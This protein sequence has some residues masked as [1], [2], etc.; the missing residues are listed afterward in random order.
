MA[1][2]VADGPVAEAG[3][4]P[5]VGGHGA[6]RSTRAAPAAAYSSRSAAPGE[7]DRPA[8]ALRGEDLL[9][10]DVAVAGVPGQLLDQVHEIQRRV[11]GPRRLWRA[12]SSRSYAAAI[13][14]DSSRGGR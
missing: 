9:A 10:Q 13:R 14:R 6:A 11:S 5:G 3:T 12:R 2:E 7:E 4:V 1:D 8:R